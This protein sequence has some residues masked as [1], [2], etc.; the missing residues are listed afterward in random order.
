MD[1]EWELGLKRYYQ[2]RKFWEKK[3]LILKKQG[4]DGGLSHKGTGGIFEEFFVTY[5]IACLLYMKSI[6]PEKNYHMKWNYK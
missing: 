3:N 6:K 4:G 5:F 1:G 2:I